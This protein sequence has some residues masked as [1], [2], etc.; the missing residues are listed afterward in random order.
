[1]N[2]FFIRKV[3]KHPQYI[4]P[5]EYMQVDDPQQVNNLIAS[6]AG[7]QIAP[8]ISE[9]FSKQGFKD[10]GNALHDVAIN[11][12]QG[13]VDGSA[14]VVNCPVKLTK[15]IVD[16]T[17]P[18]SRFSRGANKFINYINDKRKI[19][20]DYWDERKAA[21]G[22]DWSKRN[23]GAQLARAATTFLPA[24]VAASGMTKALEAHKKM[25]LARNATKGIAGELGKGGTSV[26]MN[27]AGQSAVNSAPVVTDTTTNALDAMST[28]DNMDMWDTAGNYAQNAAYGY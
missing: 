15:S 19:T 21:D 12:G 14:A 27:A 5:M 4:D 22:K 13:I 9:L 16:L 23:A 17:F 10:M 26:A 24:T 25:G 8:V 6:R 28:M 2:K 20:N 18:N 3:A 11:A 7:Q 1:M